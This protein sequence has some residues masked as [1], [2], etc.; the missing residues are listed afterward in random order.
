MPQSYKR[1]GRVT[2][3]EQ[4]IPCVQQAQRYVGVPG[5]Y[6]VKGLGIAAPN[7]VQM[8][9]DCKLRGG[10]PVTADPTQTLLY[11]DDYPNGDMGAK[12]V[13]GNFRSCRVP[14]G[15]TML[16]GS[17]M[18]LALPKRGYDI[19]R[20]ALSAAV[21]FGLPA[22][23]HYKAPKKYKRPGKLG[24]VTAVVGLYFLTSFIYGKVAAA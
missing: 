3:V 22:L 20:D 9:A 21:A 23:Y 8:E 11:D 12:G 5:L 1:Y 19:K 14:D 4:C 13:T 16:M 10:T 17:N 6:G 2:Q 18:L 7:F 24:A 15:R